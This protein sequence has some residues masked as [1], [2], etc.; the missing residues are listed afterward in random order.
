M[1]AE[2]KLIEKLATAIWSALPYDN[3]TC[4]PHCPTAADAAVALR[5]ALRKTGLAVAEPEWIMQVNE[6]ER[7]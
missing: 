4:A 6:G 2:E 7:K 1:N 3:A 5:A